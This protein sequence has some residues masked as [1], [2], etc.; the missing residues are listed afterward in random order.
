MTRAAESGNRFGRS[1]G[2]W[3]VEQALTGRLGGRATRQRGVGFKALKGN[4]A[5]GRRGCRP[6]ETA[7]GTTDPGA[8]QRP[9]GEG[10]SARRVSARFTGRHNAKRATAAVTRNGCDRGDF[11]E[12]CER[13]VG[14]ARHRTTQDWPTGSDRGARTEAE[15]TRTLS[16]TGMQQ[17]QSPADGANRWG[18]EKPR[19]RN[20]PS[21]GNPVGRRVAATRLGSGHG[22]VSRTQGTPDESQERRTCGVASPGR[23]RAL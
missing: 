10:R 11:F 18:G 5:H 19:E 4:Q 16:G 6:P 1:G 20:A 13:R 21:G 17:A 23:Q 14:D 7:D 9:E 22:R 8:E 15:T 12:G 2:G 3:V